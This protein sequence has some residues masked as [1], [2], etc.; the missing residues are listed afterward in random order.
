MISQN[1]NKM[2]RIIAFDI[3][4]VIMVILLIFFHCG[5]SFMRSSISPEIW[6]YK[7]ETTSIVFDAI[8]GFI[9]TFRHPTFFII[10]GFV[11]EMM[12][13]KYSATQVFKKRFERL[14]IPFIIIVLLFSH[15]VHYLLN[16]LE[17][18]LFEYQFILDSSYV[19]FL[20]YLIFYSLIHFLYHKFF[21]IKKLFKH[22]N[23]PLSLAATV[24]YLTTSLILFIWGENS[25]FGVYDFLPQLGSLVGY[26]LFYVLGIYF[27]KNQTVFYTLKNQGW[28]YFS[29][30]FTSLNIYFILSVIELQNQ[31][32][33]FDFNL[34]LMLSYNFSAVFISLGSIGLALKYY[35]QQTK[36]ISYI[37]KSSYFLYL[38]HFPFTLLFL[39]LINAT[40]WNV[41]TKFITVFCLT[42]LTS[43]ILNAIWRKIW[44]YN[45]PI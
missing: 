44:K 17:F 37:S 12:Y 6:S 8:L 23:L 26:F 25:F 27:F 29:L 2:P 1:L 11:S 39:I 40:N 22:I 13:K 9:H 38:V 15:L 16:Y 35:T 18:G 24:I 32:T 3:L 4:R 10:S 7:N 34:W 42:L 5:V 41:F 36:I 45:P 30:G 20:Y 19:W 33:T 14:F 21:S 43:F 28:F 31:A